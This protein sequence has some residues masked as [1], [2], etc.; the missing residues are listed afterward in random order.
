MPLTAIQQSAARALRPHR[1]KYSYVAGGAALNREWPR[2]S[3]DMDIFHDHGD[4]LPDSVAPELEALRKAG[5]TVELTSE[6]DLVVEAILR[7]GGEETRIQWFR[8]EETCRRFFPALDDP[9]FGFRLHDADVAVNKV[10]CAARRNR[11]ARDAVDLVNI[12]ERYAPLGP[13]V[14][15]VSGKTLDMAPPATLRGIRTNAFGYAREEVETVRMADGSRMDWRRLRDVLDRALDAAAEYC[16][17][18]APSEYPGC[19][20][21]DAD[22]RP[23]EADYAAIET[24]RAIA[25]RIRNFSGIPAIGGQ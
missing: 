14:W 17:Y 25:M 7:K 23:V 12:V 20:F 3:D 22:Q 4:R 19:L 24:D 9:D 2:V 21:V 18:K 15:A 6:D 5:F 16:E 11:A 8:G 10:L 1:S 13:L